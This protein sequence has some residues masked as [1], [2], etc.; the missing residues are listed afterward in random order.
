MVN[1]IDVHRAEDFSTRID[2][3]V[4]SALEDQAREKQLMTDAVTAA[5]TALS[6]ARKELQSI[7][8]L[9]DQRD[10]AVVDAIE[11]RLSGVGTEL[12]LNSLVERLDELSHRKPAD[13]AVGDLLPQLESL[14]QQVKDLETAFAVADPWKPA[15]EVQRALQER[16]GEL[17][18]TFSQGLSGLSESIYGSG[19]ALQKEIKSEVVHRLDSL[20]ETSSAQL[21]LARDEVIQRVGDATTAQLESTRDAVIQRVLTA[22]TAQLESTRDEVTQGLAATTAEQSS[23]LQASRTDMKEVLQRATTRL[24]DK[25]AQHQNEMTQVLA[26][27]LEPY[28]H[29]LQEFVEGIRR[30]NSR[31]GKTNVQIEELRQALVAH[32]AHRE[33]SLEQLREGVVADIV[34]QITDGLEKPDRKRMVDALRESKSRKHERRDAER[35]RKLVKRGKIIAD[36]E[37]PLLPEPP[38][39]TVDET[40][41]PPDDASAIQTTPEAVTPATPPAPR[42]KSSTAKS[43]SKRPSKPVSAGRAKKR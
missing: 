30:T 18:A 8:E 17:S 42:R 12:T 21:A 22:I 20:V 7:R 19:S 16:L 9:I 6:S 31:I 10:R 27:L 41:V 32:V 26:G 25:L 14:N 5:T 3:L 24:S 15:A 43:V 35:Y 37:P 4:A 1:D 23:S 29:E 28:E 13:E 11:T 34:A 38:L 40:Q 36:A 39:L 33:L 2:D